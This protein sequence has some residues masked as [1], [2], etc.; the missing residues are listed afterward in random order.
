VREVALDAYAHQDLPFEQLVEALQPERNLSYQPLFQ[1]MFV[2]QNAPMPTLELPGLTLNSLALDTKV[3]QFDLTLSMEDTEQG[4]VG[5]VQYN[6]DLFDAS[7]MN[8]MLG[9]FQTLLEGIVAHPKQR[10]KDLPLLTQQERQQLLV[11]WNHTSVD[12]PKHLCIH[13]LFEAQ[14]ERTPDAVALVFEDQQLTYWELNC[15]ANFLAHDLRSLGIG[16]DALVGLYLERSVEMVVG[17]LGTLKAGGAYV[18]LDPTYPSDRLCY[19][20]EDASVQVLLTT[21]RLVSSLPKHNARVVC[22][23]T[24]E[25]KISLLSTS[26]PTTEVTPDNLAYVIYTSGST[27]KPKGAMNTHQGIFN[28]LLWMQETYQLTTADCVLQKTPF[29]FDVSVW[30]FF[31]PLLTGARLVVAKPG[32]HQ[33]SAYLVNVILEQ[34]ITT[35]H[36]VPSMLQVFLEEQGLERCSCLQRTFCSGEALSKK[37]EE[38]FF[39]RRLDSELHNLYGPTEAAIDVTF[40]ECKPESDLMT[41]PIGCPI[42][43]TQ[44]YILDRDLQ[45]VPIGVKGELHRAC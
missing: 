20:L 3:A 34:Q 38:R 4:L 44:M 10:L 25:Q 26:N 33:D 30:E 27:G 24:L 28:R 36:F 17:L 42:A 2:L 40:W 14:V 22:L 35:L 16:P 41:V 11:E 15:R 32:G 39:A 23:D 29:S 7:T 13:Q 9:H 21:D 18:P 37:L 1:V 19:M 31:W 8:R 5:W 45:A 6:S 12:Y 43:N